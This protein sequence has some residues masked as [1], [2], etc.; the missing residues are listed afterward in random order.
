VFPPGRSTVPAALILI[1]ALA[2]GSCG[3]GDGE[4]KGGPRES[5]QPGVVEQFPAPQAKT[6]AELRH[7]LGPGPRMASSVSV[8]EPGWNRFAFALFDRT[9]RQIADTPA[10]VYVA[11]AGGGG[12]VAGPFP[13]RYQSLDVDERHHSHTVAEDDD[14]AHSIYVARIPFESAGDYQVLG[15]TR[16]DQRLVGGTPVTVRVG[17]TKMPPQ[18]GDPAPRVHTP[19]R[20]DVADLGAIDTRDPPS[21]LHEADLADVLGRRPVLLLF[22]TPRLCRSRVCGPVVDVL[23]QLK[24]EDPGA[25]A[26]IHMEIWNDNRREAGQR[27]QV[28]AYGIPSEP[29][30]FAI[31]ADGRVAARIEGAFSLAEARAALRKAMGR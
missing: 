7:G 28:R 30:L 25:A 15:V 29:W 26:Y 2:L 12:Q 27:P 11:P 3:G 21:D 17:R 14:A 22:A 31:G 10:A 19:T 1:G 8:L 23:E 13:A 9:K 6:L 18:V 20:Q 16:L 24:A 4:G 5:E